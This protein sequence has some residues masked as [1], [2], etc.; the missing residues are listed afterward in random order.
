MI[1]NLRPALT[2][3]AVTVALGACSAPPAAPPVVTAPKTVKISPEMM[4]L[5]DMALE[6]GLVNEARQRYVRLLSLDPAHPGARL[7]LAEALLAQDDVVHA[8][9]L[10]EEL[11]AVEEVRGRALLG[12]GLTM[13]RQNR[14]DDAAKVL[15]AAVEVD[16]GLWRGWN[17]LGGLH[18]LARRFEQSAEAY[19]KA[20]ALRPESGIVRNNMGFSQLLQGKPDQA[21]RHLMAALS[22]EPRLEA[23]QANLRLALALQGQYEDARTGL[24][25][26][27]LPAALNNIGFVAL[28]RG[29][30]GEAEALLAQAIEASPHYHERASVNLLRTRALKGG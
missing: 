9:E 19:D 5:A 3:L 21:T 24:T 27:R 14:R 6:D 25:K 18:D 30:F 23:A 13:I 7:G 8:R 22:H 20:L 26:D 12:K 17:A 16:P 10:F 2:V 1:S 15:A 28:S 4:R 11:E 29:D